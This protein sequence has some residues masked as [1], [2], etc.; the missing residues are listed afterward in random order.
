MYVVTLFQA[1]SS[2]ITR[3]HNEDR[4]VPRSDKRSDVSQP[5]DT[6]PGKSLLQGHARL[7]LLALWDRH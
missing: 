7:P 2:F 1:K 3:K 5:G 6:D 4:E